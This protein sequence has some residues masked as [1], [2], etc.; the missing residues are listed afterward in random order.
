M[1]EGDCRYLFTPDVDK[2]AKIPNETKAAAYNVA[3]VPIVD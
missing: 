3:C 2:W 1:Y